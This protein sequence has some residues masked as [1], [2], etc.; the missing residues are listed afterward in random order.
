MFSTGNRQLVFAFFL[1]VGA[2]V[3]IFAASGF[4]QTQTASDKGT[5]SHCAIWSALRGKC[6][7]D[8]PNTDDVLDYPNLYKGRV[9]TLEGRVDN[10]YSPTTFAMQD[11]YDLIQS[12][13]ILMISVMPVGAKVTTTTTTTTTPTTTTTTTIAEAERLKPVP[14]VEMVQ[15]LQNGFSRGKIIRATGTV[16]MFDRAA[17]EQEFGP[18][19]FGSTPLEKYANEPVLVLGANEF[20]QFQQQN[21]VVQEAAVIPPPPAPEVVESAPRP[22]APLPAPEPE[23]QPAPAPQIAQAEP[24]VT[25]PTRLPKTASPFPLLG[26]GGLLALFAGLWIRL[27]RA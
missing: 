5:H 17:L 7:K 2:A 4:A 26:F 9:V 12:D 22:E 6:A 11:N 8:N 13:R 23:V 21:R 27:Y 25:T 10:L 24:E 18:I 16:R 20:A 15:L 14:A 1:V 19:D 3:F